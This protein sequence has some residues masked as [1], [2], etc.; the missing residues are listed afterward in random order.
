MYLLIVDY[1]KPAADVAPHKEAHQQWVKQQLA[2][3]NICAAGPMKNQ[4]GGVLFAK[5]MDK[6]VLKGIIASDPYVIA[7]VADYRIIDFNCKVTSD[8]LSE[9]QTL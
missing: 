3:D 7:D 6:D 2:N 8:P 1:T 5:S 9:L 4:L